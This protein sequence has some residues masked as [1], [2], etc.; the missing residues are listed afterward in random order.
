MNLFLP[1]RISATRMGRIKI[2]RGSA[3]LLGGMPGG[4][5]IA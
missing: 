4:L 2:A 1:N 3:L 5:G